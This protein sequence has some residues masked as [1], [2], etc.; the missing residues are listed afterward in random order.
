MNK[1]ARLVL[2]GRTPE[3]KVST[4]PV[5]RH[6][7]EL[8][9]AGWS[10]ARIAREAKV[11]EAT[12]WRVRRADKCWNLVADAFR[13]IG[14]TFIHLHHRLAISLRRIR[15]LRHLPCPCREPRAR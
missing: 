13:R 6:L 5:R 2:A 1:A 7:E 10:M 11:C 9:A 14:Q 8:R 4:A 3:W 15:S 12:V